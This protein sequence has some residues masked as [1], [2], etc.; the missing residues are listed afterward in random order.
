MNIIIFKVENYMKKLFAFLLACA[1]CFLL[2]ACGGNNNENNTDT[3]DPESLDVLRVGVSAV[4]DAPQKYVFETM[5]SRFENK[6]YRLEFVPFESAEAANTALASKEIDVSLVGT[7]AEFA[8]YD[9]ENPDVL[10]NLGA[11]YYS[12]YGL[13]LCNFEN[14]EKI[15]DGAKVAVPSDANGMAHALLLLENLGFIKVADSAGIEPALDDIEENSHS[16]N[17][18]TQPAEEIAGNIETRE[19]DMFIM[20]A[21]TAKAAGY[22]VNKYAVAIEGYSDAAVQPEAVVMLINNC[23]LYTSPSPRD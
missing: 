18:V 7:K 23:L 19:A 17:F 22:A 1:M 2:C 16:F 8:A 4:E 15:A 12:P 20:S 13:Y 14:M 3:I 9:A 11:T 10:L 5:H 21:E 6:G